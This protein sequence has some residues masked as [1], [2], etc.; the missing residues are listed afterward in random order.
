[1]ALSV[2]IPP[3]LGGEFEVFVNSLAQP[4]DIG[5]SQLSYLDGLDA[6]VPNG[7]GVV[8]PVSFLAGQTGQVRRHVIRE[9]GTARERINVALDFA[10]WNGSEARLLQLV[11]EFMRNCEVT[12][13]GSCPRIQAD[14]HIPGIRVSVDIGVHHQPYS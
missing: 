8:S 3:N 9:Q 7:G 13:A 4:R 12:H 11:S 2:N 1:M 14:K 10:V 6:Q 5:S